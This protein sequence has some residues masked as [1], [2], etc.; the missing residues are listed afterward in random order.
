MT[1]VRRLIWDPGNVAHVAKHGVLPAEVEEVC[2]SDHI[3]RTA[4]RGRVMLIGPTLE[5]RMLAVVLEPQDQEG[6]FHPVTARPASRNERKLYL[7]ERRV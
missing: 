4:S 6:V 7:K 5:N 2:G 3:G 1:F